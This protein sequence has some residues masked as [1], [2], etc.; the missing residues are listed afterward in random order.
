MIAEFESAETMIAATRRLRAAG[1]ER[2]E[3]YSP[4]PL[5]EAEP[6]LGL[7]RPRFPWAVLFAGLLGA[8]LGFGAQWF[9]NA[10]DFPINVGG[11]PLFAAPAWVPITFE[12][13]ILSAAVGAVIALL[14]STGLP[15]LWNPLFEVEGFARVTSDGFW[16]EIDPADPRFDVERTRRQLEQLGALRVARPEPGP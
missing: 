12:M 15:R 9:T 13:G 14:V 1:Y 3:L 10:W 7:R 11:R 4:Y 2:L 6:L 8:G 16:L 5:D